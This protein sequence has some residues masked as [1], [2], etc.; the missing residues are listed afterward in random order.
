MKWLAT[1]LVAALL[2]WVALA[3]IVT[4][5]HIGDP[6]E[7][8]R[9]TNATTAWDYYEAAVTWV[10][11]QGP[12]QIHFV[13]FPGDLTNGRELPTGGDCWCY[14]Q[15]PGVPDCSVHTGHPMGLTCGAAVCNDP[16]AIVCDGG[17]PG[18][19]CEWERMQTL[20]DLLDSADMPWAVV[21]GNRDTDISIGL[22][23]R[24]SGDY[25]T[26]FGGLSQL[27]TSTRLLHQG[28]FQPTPPSANVD[29]ATVSYQVFTTPEGGQ[30]LHFALSLLVLPE[31]DEWVQRIAARF[32]GMPTFVSTHYGVAPAVGGIHPCTLARWESAWCRDDV[33]SPASRVF[34][35]YALDSQFLMVM[36]GHFRELRQHTTTTPSG[37]I[38]LG[39]TAD[40]SLNDFGT[41]GEG[42]PDWQIPANGGGGVVTMI[43]MN[44]VSGA[45][46]V[47]SYSPYA[48]DLGDPQ[49]PWV[50][51][52]GI[53]DQ[54]S[55]WTTVIPLCDDQERF[56]FPEGYCPLPSRL[57]QDCCE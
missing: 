35:L 20:V 9:C 46:S 33:E 1:A 32:D 42:V 4:I 3:E 22:G 11:N 16:E 40:Y 6:Q 48:D 26:Y 41:V 12:D 24:G 50:E 47:Q 28:V 43:R 2:P 14:A 45:I 23:G 10:A 30:F 27:S 55:K 25:N 53:A 21:P 18:W 38:L 51:R 44:T 8:T 17:I 39:L 29:R 7:G 54:L 34:D 5:A 52:F 13:T 19:W 49:G 57:P 56:T 36:G 31:I 15:G 37:R